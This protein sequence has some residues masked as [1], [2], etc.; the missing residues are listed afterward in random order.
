M[1]SFPSETKSTHTFLMTVGKQKAGGSVAQFLRETRLVQFNMDFKPAL[2][3]LLKQ[4]DL[5]IWRHEDSFST[6]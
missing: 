5:E 2:I 4:A 1:S 3:T 6:F